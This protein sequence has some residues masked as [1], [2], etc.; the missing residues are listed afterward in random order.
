MIHFDNSQI[1][2]QELSALEER[3]EKLVNSCKKLISENEKLQSEI[4]QLSI[5]KEQL[6]KTNS[7]AYSRVESMVNRL[8]TL[9][10]DF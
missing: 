4:K 3:V 10:I 1:E 7:F 9:E 2:E 6:I 5:E 8:K